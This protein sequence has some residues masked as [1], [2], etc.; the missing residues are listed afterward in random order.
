[1]THGQAERY[2]GYYS[3]SFLTSGYERRT[4]HT[5]PSYAAPGRQMSRYA[6][7]T[8]TLPSFRLRKSDRIPK[9]RDVAAQKE[10]LRQNFAVNHWIEWPKI[11]ERLAVCDD[12]DLIPSARSHCRTGRGSRCPDW[13]CGLLSV[14]ARRGGLAFAMAGAYILAR[15]LAH[16]GGDHIPR[17]R[18]TRAGFGPSLSASRSRRG[19]LRPALRLRHRSV[20]SCAISFVPQFDSLCR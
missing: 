11:E 15:E 19:L 14:A 18:H 1:M 12:L 6:L 17:S 4:E 9:V 2:M 5:Y 16:S 13:R 3:A 10:I 20:S 8:T 7:A